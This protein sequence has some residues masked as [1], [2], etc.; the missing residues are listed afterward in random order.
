[1]IEDHRAMIEKYL[2]TPN[3]KHRLARVMG[4]Y[5]TKE[6]WAERLNKQLLM[7]KQMFS[8]KF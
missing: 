7:Y 5:G 1:M 6:E 3:G 2:M 8:K 4:F